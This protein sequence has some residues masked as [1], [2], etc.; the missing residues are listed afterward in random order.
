[1]GEENWRRHAGTGLGLYISRQFV[2]LH[3]GEMGV[4]STLGKGT[5]FFF[6][7]PLDSTVSETHVISSQNQ[8]PARNNPLILM[9]SPN[10][11]DIDL[12]KHT[13]DGYILQLVS[14]VEQA[15]ER[16]RELFPR[17]ILVA[18]EA[19][20]LNPEQL[21]YAL[22]V[23]K[24]SLSRTISRKENPQAHLVKP[25]SRQALLQA[26]QSLGADVHNLLVLDDDPAMIRFVEQS[27]RAEGNADLTTGYNLL[28]AFTGAEGYEVLRNNDID[29]ILLDLELPDIHGWD[30]LAQLRTRPEMAQIPIVVISAED[31]PQNNFVPGAS[32]LELALHRSLS[33]DELGSVV[34]SVLE[35]ILPQYP[36]EK[37]MI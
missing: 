27:F 17:A 29:A 36:K 11:E 19:G 37:Q 12:L 7:L 25:I 13:L 30:W 6:T 22:P 23:I 14:N 34:K 33:V 32:V 10:P 1:M 8:Q 15:K 5:R 20:I 21:P 24:F 31:I 9:V 26:I 18:S 35:N 16:T 28:S 3:G 2:E 4:E